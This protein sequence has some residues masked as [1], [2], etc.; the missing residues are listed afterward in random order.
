MNGTFLIPL[1]K[2]KAKRRKQNS[3]H[4]TTCCISLLCDNRKWNGKIVYCKVFHWNVWCSRKYQRNSWSREKEAF[5]ELWKSLKQ[6]YE[7]VYKIR[8]RH[9]FLSQ[10]I[11][12]ITGTNLLQPVQMKE[13]SVLNFHISA[14]ISSFCIIWNS[15]PYKV[16]LGSFFAV[17]HEVS[18][19]NLNDQDDYILTTYI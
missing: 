11:I 3:L 8:W 15:C 14:F 16:Y 9:F 5:G 1:Y 17:W 18:A 6:I 13:T 10:H 4:C 12:C 7:C 2:G 19:D